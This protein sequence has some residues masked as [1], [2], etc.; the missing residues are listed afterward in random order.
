[1]IC[2]DTECGYKEFV[3]L[4]ENGE[5][6]YICWLCTMV[7]EGEKECILDRWGEE[8]AEKIETIFNKDLARI[9]PLPQVAG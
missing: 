4:T 8:K 9:P 3:R 6:I 1:M 5:S 2:K 7:I